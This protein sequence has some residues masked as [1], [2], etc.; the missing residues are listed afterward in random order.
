M[1]ATLEPARLRL[2]EARLREALVASMQEGFFVRDERGMRAFMTDVVIEPTASG[3]TV[4][5]SRDVR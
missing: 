1:R 4:R 5:M 3:T 2:R